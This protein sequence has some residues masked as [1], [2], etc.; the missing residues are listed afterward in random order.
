VT[1]FYH[2]VTPGATAPAIGFVAVRVF[3]AGAT[4]AIGRPLLPRLVAAGHEVTGMTRS[5]ERAAGV[6]GAGARAVVCDV[7][8]ADEL[9]RAIADARPEA[10]VH[11]LTALPDRIDYRDPTV[12]EPTNR[13]RTEGTRILLDAARAAGT[14][15]MVVQSIA[16]IYESA[17]EWV[18]S[19]EDAVMEDAPGSFGT[20]VRAVREMERMVLEA[21]ELEGLV[22]RYGFFYGPGTAY[23]ADGGLAEDVRRRR[24]PIVGRGEGVFSLVHVEDAADA[25]VAAVERG[26]PGVYNVVDDEPAPV[27]EWLPEFAEAIGAPRPLRVPR[28][29]ARLVAGRGA[30]AFATESRGASNAKAKRELGWEPDHRTWRAGFAESLR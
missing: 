3:V 2:S 10:L 29:L 5:E 24:M 25:T 17:G 30:V 12:Y 11:Q 14:R 27:R 16:F 19:E 26:P 18:K 20:A 13:V 6:R 9:R 21:Q 7:F 15:R 8:D 22:L 1:E 28:W 4:G 23:A